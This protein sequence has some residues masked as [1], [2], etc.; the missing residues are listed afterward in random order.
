MKRQLLALTLAVSTTL[1]FGFH[2]ALAA[3]YQQSVDT[4]YQYYNGGA[5]Y[6]DYQFSFHFDSVSQTWVDGSD[7]FFVQGN[8]N[9]GATTSG[10]Y[11]GVHNADGTCHT[12]VWWADVVF[13]NGYKEYPRFNCYPNGSWSWAQY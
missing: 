13:T 11:C 4:N 8:I 2:T 10:R 12:M 1:G 7:F 3:S 9:T 5:D 6:A